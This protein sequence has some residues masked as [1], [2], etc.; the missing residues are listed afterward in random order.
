MSELPATAADFN[1]GLC[2]FLSRACTPF[3]AVAV[4]MEQ[5]RDAGFHKLEETEDWSLKAGGR[6]YLTRNDSSLIA[7]VVGEESGPVA[8]VRMVGAHTDSPT[9]MVKPAPEKARQG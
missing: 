9:L 4:M 6:Y 2:E 8:G 3:H 5:L 1:S 7:F